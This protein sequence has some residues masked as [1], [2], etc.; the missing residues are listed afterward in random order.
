MSTINNY[1][2]TIYSI[3]PATYNINLS[4]QPLLWP[5]Q[6]RRR[7]YAPSSRAPAASPCRRAYLAFC[8]RSVEVVRGGEYMSFLCVWHFASRIDSP[9]PGETCLNGP[10]EWS[11]KEYSIFIHLCIH[12][13][14]VLHETRYQYFYELKCNINIVN[15]FMYTCS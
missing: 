9:R 2:T 14:S 10:I 15:A 7:H 5:L 4:N 1:I 3:T 13:F 6:S 11:A 12:P 8:S